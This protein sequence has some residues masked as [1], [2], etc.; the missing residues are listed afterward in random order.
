LRVV[1]EPFGC[2]SDGLCLPSEGALR[3]NRAEPYV[4]SR[5]TD[6]AVFLVGHG[7]EARVTTA[8]PVPSEVEGMA[9]PRTVL[10]TPKHARRTFGGSTMLTT[11][12][13]ATAGKAAQ[14]TAGKLR[15]EEI[16]HLEIWRRGFYYLYF[17]W[18]LRKALQKRG[19]GCFRTWNPVVQAYE[20]RPNEN[21]E[22]FLKRVFC[23]S[24]L[25][26]GGFEVHTR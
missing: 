25:F 17:V 10:R 20:G 23:A 3:R 1:R 2:C 24:L 19:L 22:V 26:F 15:G 5:R 21:I 9:V 11:G 13:P 4:F 18:T 16:L 8:R 7:L 6:F 14:A 12:R